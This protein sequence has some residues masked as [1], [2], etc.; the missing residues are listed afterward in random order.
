M[1]FSLAAASLLA[2]ASVNA[3]VYFKETFSNPNSLDR[4][5]RSK[6]RDDY[7]ELKLSH[8]RWYG[9][10]EGGV[11]LQLAS[12]ARFYGYSAPLDET[13]DTEEKDLIVQ[14]TVKYE[15]IIDCGG[16]YIKLLPPTLDQEKFD[17]ESEYAIMFGPDVCGQT[18]RRVHAI[19]NYEGKN[20]DNKKDIQ[21]RTDQLTHQYTFWLK[22]DKSFEVIIDNKS[23]LN[24]TLDEYYNALPP[25]EIPDPE[26]KKP[27][28]WVDE[29]TIVDP[30]DTKPEDWV[31]GP[32]TIPDPDVKKPEDWDDDMDGDWVPPMIANPEYKG[33][34]KPKRIPNPEYKGI[35]KAPLIPNP[36]YTEDSNF[37]TYNIG[38]LGLDLWTVKSGTIIDNII[39]TDNYD[40]AKEFGDE[41]WANYVQDEID[42]FNE[43]EKAEKEELNRQYDE[44]KEKEEEL[45]PKKETEA[46][47]SD[48]D[49]LDEEE[50][51]DE[52]EEN[53][54]DDADSEDD[55]DQAIEDL[56]KKSEKKASGDDDETIPEEQEEPKVEADAEDQKKDQESKAEDDVIADDGEE[57]DLD[58]IID[59]IIDAAKIE[60]ERSS[61]D[62][63][64]YAKAEDEEETVHDEL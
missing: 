1:K 59:S 40:E 43:F 19:L 18:N 25:R 34:W 6:V 33:E 11:G 64:E 57:D 26:A 55:L 35:W 27:E 13:F 46:K 2:L 23:Q 60:R 47:E 32:K 58:A 17:G 41:K 22:A 48:A 56:I 37:G 63:E 49:E 45:K 61:N 15:Q 9:D 16:A 24:G 8:G 51:D 44:L 38:F 39:V 52:D 20:H 21:P 12:D 7:G 29:E 4:W 53:K 36:D 10:E 3:K 5:V 54:K 42:S 62:K 31:D 50:K 28:D 30:E 14:F